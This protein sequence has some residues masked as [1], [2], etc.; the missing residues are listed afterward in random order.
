MLRPILGITMGDAA[1]VGPEVIVKALADAEMYRIARPLVY[2]DAKIMERAV[3][4]GG[5]A[6][7]CHGVETTSLPTSPLHR[8]MDAQDGRRTST[9]SA[10]A[11]MP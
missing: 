2:G 7:R 11:Q 1:G 4:I 10:P 8:W 9:S 6:M 3:H 5:A